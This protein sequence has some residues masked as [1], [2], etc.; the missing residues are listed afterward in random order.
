MPISIKDGENAPCQARAVSK[1]LGVSSQTKAV[2]WRLLDYLFQI[3]ISIALWCMP[4]W[5]LILLAFS[6][7]Y[8]QYGPLLLEDCELQDEKPDVEAT[9][10]VGKFML[11]DTAS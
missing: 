3:I 6:N 8:H 1:N 4:L 9:R 10:L 2:R 7:P 5:L 11:A